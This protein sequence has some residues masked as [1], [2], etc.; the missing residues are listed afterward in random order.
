VL[1]SPE[2][3]VFPAAADQSL[4]AARTR[5]SAGSVIGRR[6]A[7]IVAPTARVVSGPLEHRREPPAR[8]DEDGDPEDGVDV[9]EDQQSLVLLEVREER[10]REQPQERQRLA[11]ADLEVIA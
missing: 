1:V 11:D 9:A 2:T 5:G 3:V 6:A 7:G 4:V 8:G 10:E